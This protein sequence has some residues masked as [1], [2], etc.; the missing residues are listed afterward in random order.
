MQPVRATNSLEV[1]ASD[2]AAAHRDPNRRVPAE[3]YS[4]LDLDGAMRVQERVRTLVGEPAPVSKVAID[5]QG[6]AVAAPFYD[7]L[8][9]E[10][11]ETVV[12]PPRGWLGIE[13]EI[14]AR[15]SHS[16]T[17]EIAEAGLVGVAGAIASLHVGIELVGTR[18]DN[19]LAAGPYG[20]LAD[21]MTAAGYVW[22]PAPWTGGV[23]VDGL[24]IEVDLDG[25]PAWRGPAKTPFGHLLAPI[26]AYGRKLPE[27]SALAAGMLVTTG[28]LCGLVPIGTARHVI[29]R[30]AGRAWVEFDVAE[31]ATTSPGVAS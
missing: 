14:A 11:G 2:L 19:R 6:E 3:Y 5:S 18:F 26:M 1:L 13:V 8:V 23:E 21:N 25:R 7:S 27:S 31:L 4:G 12:R 28:T 22:S 29:A 10:S 15:L 17:R 30:V 20:P 24:L 9:A 16:I